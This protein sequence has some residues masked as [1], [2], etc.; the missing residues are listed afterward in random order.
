MAEKR[1]YYEVLGVGKT[2]TA[3]EIKQY[4][5]TLTKTLVIKQLKRSL[6]RLLRH[7]RYCLT[8]RNANVM[9]SSVT[10]VWVAQADSVA[11]E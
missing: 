2:A 6:K 7:T 10:Q 4:S 5:I 3:D 9:I 8:H 1:D 11:V